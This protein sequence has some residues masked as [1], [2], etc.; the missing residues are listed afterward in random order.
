MLPDWQLPPGVDRG[1][2]DYLHADDMV[3]GYDEFS[4]R[5]YPDYPGGTSR[6]RWY[7]SLLRRLMESENFTIYEY[8]W[9]HFDF[10]DWRSY[11]IQNVPFEQLQGKTQ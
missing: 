2:W 8:E 1:L 6:A 4:T 5:S 7:R 10:G 11:G 9:W 3:A